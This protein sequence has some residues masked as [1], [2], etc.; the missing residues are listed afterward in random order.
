MNHTSLEPWYGTMQQQLSIL[1]DSCIYISLTDQQLGLFS[2]KKLHRLFTISSSR[3]GIGNRE[4]SYQTPR[5]LHTIVEKI[6][7][8][9][10]SGS[11]LRD[12]RDT[13]VVWTCALTEDNLILSRILRLRG[14]EAGINS[15]PG[16]DSFNR[17]IY[18][19]GTN[20]EACIGTPI[21]HGCICMK[22]RDII[23][24]FDLIEEG[25]I[26]IID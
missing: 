8:G 3:F 10:P 26:V 15:G 4:G 16:I 7:E 19:H 18:I 17:Y 1:P 6:G 2:A 12:R 11:I 20:Q 21:S 5:G 24:L 23:E 14:L 25:T 9:L 13:G 22:N